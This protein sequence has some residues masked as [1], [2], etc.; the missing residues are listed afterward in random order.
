[1]VRLVLLPALALSMLPNLLL[2]QAGTGK[3]PPPAELVAHFVDGSVL[4]RVRLG[5]AIEV[6]TRYGKLSV[7]VQDVRRIEF[8]TRLS[9]E[10]ARRVD[11]AIEGLGARAFAQREAATRELLELGARAHPAVKKAAGSPDKEVARRAQEVL[12]QI[13]EAVPPE[14]LRT[15]AQDL[16]HTADSM[17][18]G[19]IVSAGLKAKTG[20]FGETT[21]A[22][23][24]LQAL[25]VETAKATVTLEGQSC[26]GAERKWVDTGILV[27]AGSDLRVHATGVMELL[28]KDAPGQQRSNPDG[29][30]N[31]GRTAENFLPGM[32]IAKV[33]E[34]G[35]PFAV[36]SHL[37]MKG[38]TTLGK[39]YVSVVVAQP[40]QMQGS[41]QL[42]VT[43]GLG[44]VPD[45]AVA[46]T[47]GRTVPAT[48]YNL[49]PPIPPVTPAAP[50]ALGVPTTPV[51]VQ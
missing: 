9:D 31:F 43:T 22:V 51:P 16:I 4:R 25:H 3:S 45:A 34:N 7:P 35:T 18:S 38:V 6:Q 47:Q 13:E 44:I 46:P 5:D 49:P 23:A 40:G 41:Y 12:T 48:S 21:L 37:Q 24:E 50:A 19:Q 20:T 14:A 15:R 26:D 29:N 27:D 42:R 8:A 28:A 1:M 32:L 30:G 11:R 10:T 17:I 33:G 39:L 36:G 2:A